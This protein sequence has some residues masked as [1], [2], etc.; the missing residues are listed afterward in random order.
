MP[1]RPEMAL[2][3]GFENSATQNTMEATYAYDTTG[4]SV[5]GVFD[6]DMKNGDIV[7]EAAT[8]IRVDIKIVNEEIDYANSSVTKGGL[9]LGTVEDR[10]GVPVIKYIDGTF[11]SLP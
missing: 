10:A 8:T 11:E 3:I 7:V 2:H 9:V 5:S 4:I 1:S 6:S